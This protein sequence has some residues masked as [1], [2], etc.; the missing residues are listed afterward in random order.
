MIAQRAAADAAQHQPRNAMRRRFALGLVATALFTIA[1]LAPAPPA[2]AADKAVKIRMSIDEDP[3]VMRL[4][5][6]LGYFKREGIEIA[7]VDLEKIS[8]EDYLMQE[9]LTKGQLDASYHWFNHAIFGARH[10]FPIQ[11]VMLFNDAPGMTVMVANRVKDQVRG[12]A[13]FRGCNVAEGASYGT[14]SVITGYLAQQAGLPRHSYTPVMTASEGRLEAVLAGLKD[15]KVDV[16]TFQEPVT[17]ALLQSKLVTTLYDLNSRA[18]TTK[19]LGAPFP[20]QSLLMS[21]MYIQTHPDTVQHLVNALTRTMRWVNSHSADEIVA[22]LPPDYFKDE[23]R[24]AQVKYIRDTLSTF[25][26][27]DYSFSPAAVKLVVD[28]VE[29][30]DFDQSVEGK[31]RASGDNSKVRPDELYNNRF[32][33]KAMMEIR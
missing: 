29:S 31:W 9:P 23:T 26:R 30:S 15:G 4:A 10:G 27:G 18:S 24:R 16:M 2:V 25:A 13:D 3:I 14:K 20:A 28:A 19:V 21:P 33:N 22:K 12:A 8:G 1:A 6:S 17:S 5:E 7:P 11:A 32:V